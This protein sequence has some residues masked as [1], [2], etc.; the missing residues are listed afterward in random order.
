MQAIE[1]R[2]LTKSFGAIRALNK[3][4]LTVPEGTICALLGPNGAGKTTAIRI[5]A[6]LTSPDAGTASV[7]GHDIARQAAL[8]RG[9][10]GLAGQHAAVDDDLTGR[11]NLVILGLMHHLGRR[12][13]SRRA[14]EMLAEHGLAD[15]AGRL[16]R[17]WSGGMRRRLDLLA[18]LVVRPAVLFLDEPTTG[19]DPRSRAAIWSSVRS[20]AA[21]GTTVLLTTQYLDEADRLASDVVIIEAG[22]T[23]AN[24]SPEAL[25]DTI[26]TR[27]VVAVEGAADLSAAASVASRWATSPPA[28][29]AEQLRLTARVA[30]G[31]VTLPELVRHLDA[32]GVRAQDV[33]F[34]RPTLD[35]VFLDRT[36]GSARDEARKEAVA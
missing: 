17:T 26:G 30:T 21:S 18:S 35:E 19:V 1:A 29:D 4:D 15:A 3:F 16:V 24:G 27:V 22:R 32:A 36:G 7:A 14:D 5:L 33:S 10:I 34:R 13:A 8:V 25:K 20:L 12:S 28:V 23:V 9:C 31:S 2:G 6:T 11:E